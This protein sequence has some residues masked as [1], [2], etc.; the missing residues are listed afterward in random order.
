[1]W[2]VSVGDSGDGKSPG[3][4][5]LMRDVLPT[6]ER[7]MIGDFPDRLRDWQTASEFDKAAL[8]RWKEELREAQEKKKPLPVMPRP[9]V[10]DIAP[11][12]PR[13]I[14]H[15]VTI[16]QIGTI[17]HTAAPKGLLVTRDEI[18]GWF[19]GMDAYNP[20]ARAFWIEAYGG[21][22]Y[23]I[24][25]RSHSHQP[26]EIAR[27]AV[28][29]YGGTQ[30]ERLSALTTGPE[31]G[32]FSRILWA[33]PDPIPF[34]LG[35]AAPG[36]AWAIEAL[37]KLRELDL[38]LGDPPSPIFMPLTPNA[39]QLMI[40]FAREM[41]A[42]LKQSGGLLRSAYG[43]A[44]GAA[45]RLSL[46]LEWLWFCGESGIAM[47]PDVISAKAFVAATTLVGEYFMPMA[48]RVFGDAA[49]SSDERG[50]AT[51]AR[52]IFKQKPEEVH[53]RHLLREVRLPGLRSA[54]QIKGA[55]KLLVDADWLRAP[56]IGFGP[57]S[58]V[59][60]AVNPRLW[61]DGNG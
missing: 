25:R 15:D 36:V 31:D 19:Q 23:K 57:Q 44:R 13:L 6:L 53:V 50:A 24:E 9:T 59:A 33:W 61:E 40:K 58:K 20:A 8:K 39:Q 46:V 14:Q 47:P 52:W 54:E 51:L 30:P 37:D 34:R 28:A 1:L 60:Y 11:E 5:C 16:E 29:L 45:L 26:I 49:A 2:V 43:K 56:N 35:E 48:E 27:L 4:D 17:L 41:A 42:D 12:R 38:A 22:P 7:Q 18:A 55:A 3:A 21:R 10:S 32:L